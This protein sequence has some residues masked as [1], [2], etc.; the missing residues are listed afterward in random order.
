MSNPSKAIV[1]H[2]F[3]GIK[4]YLTPNSSPK[5]ITPKYIVLHYTASD[6]YEQCID[7]FMQATTKA[8]AHFVISREGSCTQLAPMNRPTWHAGV[9][10]Y[11]GQTS[12]NNLS[13]GIELVNW[14]PL[15]QKQGKFYSWTNKEIDEDDVFTDSKGRAWQVYTEA[16]LNKLSSMLKEIVAQYNIEEIIRHEDI[17]VPKGRKQDTGPAMP[18][19]ILD[20]KKYK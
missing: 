12:I 5:T 2:E 7:R 4:Q 19:Y 10:A 11:K 8:S 15:T 14:G 6:R 20:I 1:D 17:C 16:Q 9:S 3:V 13:V 18:S